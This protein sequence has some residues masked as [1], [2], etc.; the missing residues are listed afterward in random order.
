MKITDIRRHNLQL[1][2]DADYGGVQARMASRLKRKPAQISQW[3][4]GYRTIRED[5]ARDLEQKAGKPPGWLD[6]NR[7]AEGS[8]L[9]ASP[10]TSEAVAQDSGKARP[11]SASRA[12]TRWPLTVIDPEDWG[13]LSDDE[14]MQL[15]AAL[16]AAL[17]DV[18]RRRRERAELDS[19]AAGKHVAAA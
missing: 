19:G 18:K 7:S 1:L 3:F 16:L 9:K 5:T 12:S 13:A 11:W 8:F 6:V 14:R 17:A 2:Q 4:A 10:V 15:E